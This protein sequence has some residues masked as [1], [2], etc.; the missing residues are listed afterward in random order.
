MLLLG[1]G[2][3]LPGRVLAQMPAAAPEWQSLKILETVDPVFPERLTRV[4]VTR[5]EAQVA[6]N[7]SAEGKLEQWLVVGYT[8]PL[9]ADA[10]VAAI[11]E[12]SYVPARL[13]GEPVGT[14]IELTF[15]FETRGVVVSSTTVGD[16][17]EAQIRRL[18]N[19]RYVYQPCGLR[20]LDRIPLPLVTVRP[21]YSTQLADQGVKG[22]VTI[23]FFIDEHGAV[24]MPAGSAA[25]DAMLTALAIN[26]LTQWK[27]EPPT[28]HGRAVLVRASQVFDFAARG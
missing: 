21:Q 10:A 24:R 16:V 23:D 9:F 7:T 20:E 4:G 13:R 12:W 18:L 2:L 14:T 28:S 3:L 8:D 11:K 27:F 6:I 5:G 19:G 15:Y 26:A 1:I 17:V 25:D 22:K